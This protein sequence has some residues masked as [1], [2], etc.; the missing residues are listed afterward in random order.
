[1]RRLRALGG[2]SIEDGRLDAAPPA[3]R[4]PLA[5]L[6]LLAIAGARG[7]SR[8]K[9]ASLLWPESDEERARN[10]LSQALS[11]LR[12][13][14]PEGDLVV[15]AAE[16]RLNPALITSDVADFEGH[17]AAGEL[18]RAVDLYRGPF[19]DGFF[20]KDAAEFERWTD[21]HRRRL[22]EMFATA[23][24]R[25][26]RQ[27]EEQHDYAAAVGRWRRLTAVE[28][29]SARAAAGLMGALAATGDR[30]AALQH[31]GV[32]DALL[33]QEFGVDPEPVVTALAKRLRTEAVVRGA[34]GGDAPVAGAGGVPAQSVA[35]EA[36]PD[37]NSPST[38]VPTPALSR[39]RRMFDSPRVARWTMLAGAVVIAAATLI[40]WRASSRRARYNPRRVVVTG[41]T[42]R[43]GDSTL[44]VLGFL[45]AD[46]ITDAL[47]RS[48]LVEVADPATSLLTV[49]GIRNSGADEKEE[50]RLAAEVVRA[51]LV[52]SGHYSREGDSI[53]IVARIAEA[54][55]GRII[56][57]TEPINAFPG[58]PGDAL[59]RVKQRVLGILAVRLDDRLRDVLTP[60]STPPPTLPAYREHVDG[61]LAFQRENTTDALTHFRRAYDLDSSFIAPLIWQVFSLGNAFANAGN[62][63]TRLRAIE[64]LARRRADLTPL[65]RH[66]LE[67]LEANERSDNDGRVAAMQQASDLAPQ[68]YWTFWL[69]RSL[70][71]EG[72]F[73]D[74]TAV[75]EQIDRKNGWLAR[76]PTFWE[77]IVEV[78]NRID[79]RRELELAREARRALPGELTPLYLEARALVDLRRGRELRQ[80]LAEMRTF[81]DRDH[82]LGNRLNPLGM[83]LWRQGDTSRA[84][85]LFNEAVAWF[86]ALP[87][88]ELEK[89]ARR[90]ELS[91]AL[92]NADRYAEA[93]PVFER[94]LAEQ[95]REFRALHGLGI[96]FARLGE[97]ERAED[98]ISRLLTGADSVDMNYQWAAGIAAVLGQRQRAVGFLQEF[99]NRGHP[100]LPRRFMFKDFDG[101]IGYAPFMA[102][103]D[104]VR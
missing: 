31:Y 5:I 49:T 87:P 61:L 67:Y 82:R 68:S 103:T 69:A 96:C 100:G 7:L 20:V 48:G 94:L 2:L 102:I 74:A 22:G 51:G 42:N 12:R 26:A 38:R 41:F 36:R 18:A 28:P 62:N 6:A 73:E 15:G 70:F 46:V 44:D 3:R 53:V 89:F 93:R 45:A 95:P 19:L 30:A 56:D 92:L 72:R 4:R 25:L 16:L 50:G 98:A 55:S 34:S 58:A 63:T 21:E 37:R 35:L 59:E 91:I 11:A 29:G 52:V 90:Q 71:W 1:M 13:D 99:K 76:W 101:M 54:A 64:R 65:D 80:V 32:H 79:H 40:A 24:Q 86:H 8:E 60:G 88:A 84:M 33:R 47:Q 43:T 97:R 27:A 81:P 9:V 57:A 10:S 104:P 14:A 17:V 66:V 85:E 39:R 77:I 83:G 78:W 75:F 23:L